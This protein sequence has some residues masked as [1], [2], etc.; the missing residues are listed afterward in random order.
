MKKVL[1]LFTVILC[2]SM[3]ATYIAGY[4]FVGKPKK[5]SVKVVSVISRAE[6]NMIRIQLIRHAT[7]LFTTSG[8]KILVDPYLA[9]QGELPPV[10]LTSPRVRNPLVPLPVK[11]DDLK[12]VDAILITHYH[13]DHFDK[14]AKKI[15]SKDTLFFCQPADEKKLKHDGFNNI[16]VIATS[17]E[18]QGLT[19]S[20]FDA[21]H[22]FGMVGKI[23]GKSSSY[24]IK[25]AYG[26]VFFTGDAVYD[27]ILENNLKANKPDIVVANAGSAKFLF[28]HPITLRNADIEKMANLLPEA[29]I[30]VEHMDAVNH[31]QQSKA[32]LKDFINKKDFID[33]VYLPQDGELLTFK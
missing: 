3:F 12:D 8:K 24:A 13:L 7:I 5:L 11:A 32:D 2:I 22:G 25:T 19:I 10:P 15:L 26:S 18:W 30:I 28:G 14:A 4:I 20:R 16:K 23:L 33:R 31:C 21:N 9:D 17:I 29:K 6:A 1:I 27:E